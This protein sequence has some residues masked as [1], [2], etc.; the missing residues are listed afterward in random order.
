M[1]KSIELVNESTE[2][3]I[4][5]NG[6]CRY[7]I[8]RSIWFVKL[9]NICFDLGSSSGRDNVN[10]KVLQDCFHVIG[11]E[12][13]GIINESLMTG[14]VPTLWKES[15]VVPIQKVSGTNKSDE[16]RP[17]NMLHTLEKILETVVKT[18]LLEYLNNN[19]LIIPEQ[20]G[21]REGHSCE[22]AL[23]LVLAKWKKNFENKE[24]TLAVFLDLKR[25]FETISRPLLLQTI[26]RFGIVGTAYKW[27]ESYLCGRT[28][29]TIFNDFVS[30]PRENDLGVPQGSVFGRFCL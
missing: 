24:S 11:Q 23:N 30:E 12:L 16:F 25:A 1:N 21:Y 14:Q 10:A 22:T 8:F 19:E 26:Q 27:F 7:E 6:K 29:R 4:P 3:R 17:I 28:Q 18:Q 15:L 5:I 2:I 9:K 13:L 20:S